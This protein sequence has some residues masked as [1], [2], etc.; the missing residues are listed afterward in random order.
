MKKWPIAYYNTYWNLVAAIYWLVAKWDELIESLE[1]YAQTI[2][3]C[4][5]EVEPLHDGMFHIVSMWGVLRIVHS[6]YWELDESY[7]DT[8]KLCDSLGLKFWHVPA[9]WISGDSFVIQSNPTISGVGIPPDFMLMSSK[10]HGLS[11]LQESGVTHLV[12]IFFVPTHSK[13][14]LCLKIW[15][16]IPPLFSQKD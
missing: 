6:K 15:I 7:Q 14:I 1:W 4:S 13:I 12:M 10:N 16:S 5:N 8:T 2:Q 11:R 9:C 3:Y